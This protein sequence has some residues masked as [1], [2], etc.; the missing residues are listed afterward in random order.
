MK[1]GLPQLLF[2]MYVNDLPSQV[3]GGLLLQYADN[4]TLIC[5]AQDIQEAAILMNTHRSVISQ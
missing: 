5:A 3:P 1:R 4:T 2:L